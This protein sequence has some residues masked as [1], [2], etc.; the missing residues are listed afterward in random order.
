MFLCCCD[1]PLSGMNFFF[2]FLIH[3][4]FLFFL[5]YLVVVRFALQPSKNS[6]YTKYA[7]TKMLSDSES[8]LFF[9]LW[10]CRISNRAHVGCVF[11]LLSLLCLTARSLRDLYLYVVYVV[12][13]GFFFINEWSWKQ[14]IALLYP[15]ELSDMF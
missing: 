3:F 15:I 10:F 4:S 2:V 6:S 7:T 11:M 12:Y 9:P 1:Y 5:F 13:F 8:Q 14:V